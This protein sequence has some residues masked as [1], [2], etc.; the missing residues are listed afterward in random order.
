MGRTRR[1]KR[2]T[3]QAD[4]EAS[5]VSADDKLPQS[6]VIGK[7]KLTGA[8]QQLVADFRRAMEPLTASKLHEKKS[9]KIADFL[10]VAGP[11]GV[12]HMVVFSGTELGTYMRLGRVPHGP[13]LT[14][15]VKSFSLC[16]DIQRA[17]KRPAAPR[18]TD[19]MQS[20]L[21]VLSNFSAGASGS[22]Q[23]QAEHR[24]TKLA[25][26]MFQNLFPSINVHNVSLP[27]LRR[28]M[29]A[30]Y[31]SG[32]SQIDLR[33]FSIGSREVGAGRK[34]GRLLKGG[35]GG[36]GAAGGGGERSAAMP[37][38][39]QLN[40]VSELLDGGGSGSDSEGEES[41]AVSLPAG[42][43]MDGSQRRRQQSRL[44]RSK[45]VARAEAAAAA[46][47]E[48]AGGEQ[49]RALRLR[50]IGPRLTLELVKVRQRSSLLKAVI[51]CLSLCFSAFPCGSTALTEDRCNQ[52]EKDFFKGDILF[53]RHFE[54][55]PE[56]VAQYKQELA[57]KTAAK[58]AR[59]AAQA[60]NV[61][62]KKQAAAQV[63]QRS[64]LLKAVITAFPSVS[65]PFLA[66][67]L[68][69][70]RTVAIRRRSGGTSTPTS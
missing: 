10:N 29:L 23:A 34:V 30:A 8:Q 44:R 16:S 42:V 58:A 54:K 12:T 33:H 17:Q 38:L 4:A 66:V 32:Q 14:Y 35:G 65:L 64:S 67:P 40:D 5:Q 37:D 48:E 36:G 51:T 63:R 55:S 47:A 11:L 1:R 22:A 28:V 59:K 15:S 50:E 68:R 27:A 7:G 24:H 20:P 56:E 31:D 2:Q 62:K 26:V 52:I 60:A 45:T 6:F 57:A 43:E 69:S 70:Q 39:S 41:A 61:E 9:N 21:V 49:Q 53:H 25:G 18:P 13:T 46:A 3:H 19:Y